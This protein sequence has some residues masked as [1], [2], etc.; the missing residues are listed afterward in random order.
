MYARYLKE[1]ENKEMLQT[2]HGFLTYG[3]NCVPGV[4]F[5]H[6]YIQDLWVKPEARKTHV[7]T[8]MADKVADI[9]K[10]KG[11]RL[12][13]GSVN[14]KA[15]N[16]DTSLKVLQSYGMRLYSTSNDAIWLFKEL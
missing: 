11:C 2:E 5:P 8:E 6:V 12:M 16:P 13:F 10:E 4:G 9:A 14:V 3:F 1:T 15:N 7:A